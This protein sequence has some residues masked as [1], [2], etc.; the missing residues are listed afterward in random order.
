MPST[1]RPN[2]RFSNFFFQFRFECIRE[3]SGELGRREAGFRTLE[4]PACTQF[5]SYLIAVFNIASSP[6]R[7]YLTRF[8]NLRVSGCPVF[9]SHILEKSRYKSSIH[10]SMGTRLV[11]QISSIIDHNVGYWSIYIQYSIYTVKNSVMYT[12]TLL[13]TEVKLLMAWN[14]DLLWMVMH[15]RK[16]IWALVGPS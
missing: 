15:S 11:E 8:L 2:K 13:I 6:V 4:L 16:P 3:V 10:R 9:F 1:G 14:R 12:T 5:W 7:V